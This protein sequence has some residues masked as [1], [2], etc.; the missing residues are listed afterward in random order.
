MQQPPM[1]GLFLY[2]V[3]CL[4]GPRLWPGVWEVWEIPEIRLVAVGEKGVFLGEE[5]RMRI[6]RIN[7]YPYN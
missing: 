5:N 4:G 6:T 3:P 7:Y 2:Q 1:I